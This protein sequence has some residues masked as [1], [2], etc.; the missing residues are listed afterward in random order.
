MMTQSLTPLSGIRVLE[1]GNDIGA[2]FCGRMLGALGAE[3]V[4][5]N[6]AGTARFEVVMP[7]GALGLY[8]DDGKLLQAPPLQIEHLALADILLTDAPLTDQ[9]PP[10]LIAVRFSAFG[11]TGPIGD[12]PGSELV[13]Q[14]ASGLL[15]LLGDPAREPV[16]LAGQQAAYSSGLLAFTA[17]MA[18]LA[19]RDRGQ[20]EPRGQTIEV[21]GLEAMANLEWK[22]PV[23][24]QASGQLVPRGKETGPLILPCRDG[25]LGFYYN[26]TQW[27]QV[28]ELFGR[29]DDLCDLRFDTQAGRMSAQ[30]EL[31][32]L[33]SAL[34]QDRSKYELYHAAQALGIPVGPVE[35]V[36]DLTV[37]EQYRTR[38]FLRPLGGGAPAGAREPGMPYTFNGV[39]PGHA[40]VR[41]SDIAKV[42]VP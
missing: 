41:R 3:V 10:G 29:P 28:L 40:P 22:G 34:T 13:V 15:A 5:L 18:A 17:I 21:S 8:L 9:S 24:Y 31:I 33:L 38:D 12:L 36:A 11:G 32:R 2:A 4:L 16:M 42:F 25:F 30:P 37:S 35:T 14:A 20:G 27:P 23:Y 7:G 1:V 39:R 19:Y 6:P 26:A